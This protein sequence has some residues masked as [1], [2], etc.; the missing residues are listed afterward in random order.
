MYYGMIFGTLL[1]LLVVIVLYKGAVVVPQSHVYIVE[2]LGKFKKALNGGFHVLI[3]FV[4]SI[5][6]RVTLQEQIIDI[7]SQNVIT[8]D[9][10]NIAIDG[11]V[12]IKVVDPVKAVYNVLDFKDAIA[13]LAQTTLRSAIGDMELDETLSN[14]AKI[15]S[16][17]QRELDDASENWG[18]KI[19]RVE[20]SD[21]SVPEEIERAMNMQME[22]EREK[23]AIETRAEAE[24]NKAFREAEAKERM[25]DAD[26]YSEIARAEGQARA[27]EAINTA[28]KENKDAAEYTLKEKAIDAY[29]KIA[30]GEGS[31]V[32]IPSEVMKAVGSFSIISD[33]FNKKG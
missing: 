1:F 26:K 2:R 16:V 5:R 9:N 7:P 17:L 30:D 18:V 12:Y 3:P 10:V 21:I 13:S 11:I 32:Y 25:A 4:D 20:V 27:I 23:R 29:S 24:K 22:A 8:K 33:I 19:T 6:D 28:M 14:R 31:K 15:N